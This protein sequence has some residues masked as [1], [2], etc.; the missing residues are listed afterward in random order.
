MHDAKNRPLKVGDRVLIPA[1]VKEL[2]AQEDYC[3]A[4]LDSAIGRRPDGSR[5]LFSAINTGVTLRS[6]SGDENDLSKWATAEGEWL[7]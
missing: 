3:N 5:E 6:N 7:G 4:T 1:I 2:Y